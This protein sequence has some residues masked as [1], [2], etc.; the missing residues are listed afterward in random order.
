MLLIIN[1]IV[2]T[3]GPDGN[4][5]AFTAKL[6]ALR[7]DMQRIESAVKTEI[8]SNRKETF[9]N[10]AMARRELA[11]SLFSFE[12]K[13]SHLTN[14]IDHKLSAFNDANTVN[15]KETRSEIRQALDSFKKDLA[16][17]IQEF[18]TIQKDNFF[19]LL[20]KQTEQNSETGKRLDSMRQT[21]EQKIAEMQ[22]GNEQKLEQMRVTVDEKLQQTLEAR[23]GES[24]K[25][26][27][28]RLEAVHKGL[29]DMQQLATG[30]GDLK[31]VLSNVKTRGVLGEYQLENILEQTLT[32]D[33]YGKNVKTKEG[34]NAMVEFAVKMPGKEKTVWLPIDSKFPKED[35]ELLMQAY[36]HGDAIQIEER[37]RAFVRGIKKCAGDICHRYI[38]P[39]NTTDFAILFLP[40][41]SLYA[42]V[43]RTPGLFESIRT[44]CKINIAGPT[45]LSAFLSSLQMGFRTLAIEKRSGEVWQLLSA[46]KT[47]FNNFSGL[48]DKAQ[49]NIQSGLDQLENVVGV[50]TRAIQKRLKGV[51]TLT[52]EQVKGILP[53]VVN[54]ELFPDDDE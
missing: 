7:G 30:V 24:F 19:A 48:L 54:G 21:L 39:P 6:D 40:F 16:Q 32:A 9:D 20:N 11:S 38:D 44:E 46:V 45:T 17:S 35:F 33:Q 25:I 52:Q 37:R 1:L 5:S 26:V 8:A 36:E 3:K 2:S 4:D 23:L 34:S 13:L 18:N 27:S 51:D 28:E 42:E 31:R 43:L 14:T 10:A 29:G 47:E 22:Q 53:E 12:E 50:R 15:S 41:E 49:K